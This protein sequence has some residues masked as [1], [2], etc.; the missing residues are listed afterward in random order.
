MPGRAISQEAVLGAVAPGARSRIGDLKRDTGLSRHK[1][2]KAAT[3][4]IRR[5]LLERVARGCFRLTEAGIAARASGD[6]LSSGPNGPHAGARRK[7]KSCLR[8]RLW[9]AMAVRDKF[10]VGDLVAVAAEGDERDAIGNA[11]KYLAALARTGY[12]RELPIRAPGVAASSGGFKRYVVLRRTGPLAPG[13]YPR[14]KEVR[15]PNTGEAR[16]WV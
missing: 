6:R 3:G 15:D 8:T 9:R 13:L 14:R 11:R 1:V 16:S 2:S 4:L 12:L 10:T 5:G 7:I